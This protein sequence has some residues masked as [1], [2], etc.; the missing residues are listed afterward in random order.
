MP[1]S[2]LTAPADPMLRKCAL[3]E[4]ADVDALDLETVHAPRRTVVFHEGDPGDYLYV[5]LAGKV[6][7]S[8]RAADGREVV[9]ALL[10]PSD[11]F[12]EV[13]LLE[14]C[15]RTATATVVTDAVL[16]RLHKADFDRW[17]TRSPQAAQQL[18]LV[19]ARRIRGSRAT[20]NELLFADVSGRVAKQLIA[21]ADQFGVVEDD[22]I[23]VDHDLTQAELA[24]FVGA[25]RESVNRVL[26]TYTDRGWIR[27][28]KMS[29]VILDPERLAGRARPVWGR[30]GPHPQ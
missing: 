16:A 3:F 7:L 15:P 28:E 17:L 12:G 19:V 9:I 24:Q 6:K 11:H 2:T 27:I 21:L 14:S 18:L 4:G 5:V 13:A 26:G 10:G 29:I 25:S 1:T 8:R 20:L 22:E 23:R 30:R